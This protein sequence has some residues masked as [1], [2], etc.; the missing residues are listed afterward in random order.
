MRT[1]W[2][3]SAILSTRFSLVSDSNRTFSVSSEQGDA[4]TNRFPFW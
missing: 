3:S 4:A 2:F 1:V